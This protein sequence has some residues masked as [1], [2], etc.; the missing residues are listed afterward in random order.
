MSAQAT[1]VTKRP[2]RRL[3]WI[4][5]AVLLLTLLIWQFYPRRGF[6]DVG[7]RL[8][9]GI[10]TGDSRALSPYLSDQERNQVLANEQALNALLQAYVKPTLHDL[11]AIGEPYFEEDPAYEQATLSQKFRRRDGEDI[12][13]V[14]A[15]TKS[16][17]GVIAPYLVS[18]LI[19][20]V[21]EAK[22]TRPSQ[23]R[24]GV[25]QARALLEGARKDRKLLE[26]LGIIRMFK[27]F[28]EGTMTWDEYVDYQEKRV[29]RI[30]SE[31]RKERE[32]P[33]PKDVNLN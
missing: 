33:G 24:K 18:H 11:D 14:I 1:I 28:R 25:R 6:R 2:A 7:E 5:L 27:F 8:L 31:I 12:S 23:D 21:Q 20:F 19:M 26:D 17:E 15:L 16:D 22:Y 13:L 4:A 3:F 32:A 30:E 9:R 29:S 10:S